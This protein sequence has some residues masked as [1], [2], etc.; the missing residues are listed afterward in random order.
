MI[1]D[2]L[3]SA[4]GSILSAVFG[5]LPT[6]SLNLSSATAIGA[7]LCKVDTLL[8]ILGPLNL[9]LTLLNLVPIFLGIRLVIVIWNAVKP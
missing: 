9:V 1:L 4:V 5:V 2:A 8:P 6:V 7:M 3:W